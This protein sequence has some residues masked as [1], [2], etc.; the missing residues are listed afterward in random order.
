SDTASEGSVAHWR[1]ALEDKRLQALLMKGDADLAAGGAGELVASL[2]Q[3]VAEHQFEERLWGQL[4]LALYRSGR[5]ADALDAYQRARRLFSSELGLEPGEPLA[6]LQQRILE[7]DPTLVTGTQTQTKAQE[8]AQPDAAPAAQSSLPRPP[9]RL[10][11]RERELT[12]L[13]GLMAD[14]DVRMVTLTGPGGVGKTRLLLESA[15]RQEQGYAHGAVFVRLERLTDPALVAAEIATSIAQRDRTDGPSADG[16]TSYLRDREMLIGIDNFEH[17]LAAAPLVAELLADAPRIRVLASS[18]TGL[19][20]RGEQTFEVDPLELPGGESGDEVAHSPAVQLLLQCALAANRKLEVDS[21]TTRTAARLCRALDGLPLAIELAASRS[22]LLSLDQIADQLTEPLSIGEHSLRDLPDRQQ[23]LHATIKW[24]YDLLAPAAREVLCS[25]AAFLGGFTLAALEAVTGGPAQLQVEEL[26]GASLARRQTEDGRFELLE[27][28]RAF[29]VDALQASGR[30][31]EAR[32]RHR[33]FFAAHVESTSERF[34]DGEAPGELAAELLHDHANLR[35][36]FEDALR[37]GDE[38][39]ALA[40]A[41]GLRPLWL[42]GMLRQE[43]HELAERLLERFSIPGQQEVALLRAVAFLDYGPS[44][45]AWHS[46]IA[47]R[48]AEIGDQETVVTAT[49]NLFGQALNARDGAEMRRLRPQLLALVTPDTSPK[50]LGWIHYFLALD[51]YVDGRYES[52]SD[53]ATSSI[54]NAREIGHEYM[55]AGAVGARLLS[56]SARDEVIEHAALIEAVQVM[57]RPSV[58]PLAAFTLWL[59]AR[60]A[61]EL[62][63]VMAGRCLAHAERI[64][65]TLDT[66]LWPECDLRDETAAILGVNDL[67]SLL[68]VTPPADHAAALDEAWAWLAERNPAEAARREMTR[69]TAEEKRA[70]GGP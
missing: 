51:A 53:H 70:V 47:R 22:H 31:E 1:R 11:G 30:A 49:G 24:S 33:R 16:L 66:D 14:P 59:V 64:V 34:D 45:T 32:G 19:R 39:S 2:Q 37:A 12:G 20:I 58:Q 3:L 25:A 26:L 7:R 40:L 42:A 13:A 43:S 10:V 9:T 50:S 44:A 4:M 29:S 28:V 63:P 60:Y 69:H 67:S 52:A 54:E 18:R 61:A 17:L 36:A 56:Q 27:L 6:Q 65:A 46:R 62:A 41:L 68:A 38:Q 57:R 15:R 35:A 21:T 8:Q 55:L 5:Q 48:A 23:T